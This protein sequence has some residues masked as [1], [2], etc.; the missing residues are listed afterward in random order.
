M[1]C[2]D[3]CGYHQKPDN[4]DTLVKH[5]EECLVEGA[6]QRLKKDPLVIWK[7]GGFAVVEKATKKDRVFPINLVKKEAIKLTEDMIKTVA[8]VNGAKARGANASMAAPETNR[9]PQAGNKKAQVIKAKLG[10]D[11]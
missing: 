3:G 7:D 1:K 2:I 10:E 11:F 9:R 6:C 4:L 8:D 5:I